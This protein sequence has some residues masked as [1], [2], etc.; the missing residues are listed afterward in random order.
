[1]YLWVA[2]REPLDA[3]DYARTA[4]LREFF[5]ASLAVILTSSALAAPFV[6]GWARESVAHVTFLAGLGVVMLALGLAGM[7]ALL[8]GLSSLSNS[9][10]ATPDFGH[11]LAYENFTGPLWLTLLLTGFIPYGLGYAAAGSPRPVWSKVCLLIQVG[12]PLYVIGYA[13]YLRWERIT[14]P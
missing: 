7:L 12:V 6:L 10:G 5:W 14:A 13:V 2:L 1:M 3:P 8:P 4:P 11:T 9:G